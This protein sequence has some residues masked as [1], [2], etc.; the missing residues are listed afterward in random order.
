[1]AS[2]RGV[3]AADLAADRRRRVL[4][5]LEAATRRQDPWFS[6]GLRDGRPV[7]PREYRQRGERLAL[8]VLAAVQVLLLIAGWY[9]LVVAVGIVVLVRVARHH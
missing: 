3:D 6:D 2:A 4:A 5:E 9:P 8:T 1:M 7:P